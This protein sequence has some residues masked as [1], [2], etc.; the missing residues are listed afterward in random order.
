MELRLVCNVCGHRV[1][2]RGKRGP[3]LLTECPACGMSSF[4]LAQHYSEQQK[5]PEV[6]HKR[7]I[8]RD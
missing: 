3:I 1:H 2:V 5:D 7:L 4:P 6:I 8:K